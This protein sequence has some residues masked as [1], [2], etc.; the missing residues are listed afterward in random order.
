MYYYQERKTQMNTI[1]FIFSSLFSN[2]KIINESKKR[3][4]WLAIIIVILSCGIAIVPTV[5]SYLNVKGSDVI[6]KAANYSADLSFKQLSYQLANLE[7]VT[8]GINNG[9]FS[10]TVTEDNH[11]SDYTNPVKVLI[12]EDKTWTMTMVYVPVSISDP[13]YNSQ[14][15]ET[16]KTLSLLDPVEKAEDS[17]LESDQ[18]QSK[19]HSMLIFTKSDVYLHLYEGNAMV[20]Y[21]ESN[22]TKTIVKNVDAKASS[23]GTFEK[24]NNLNISAFYDNSESINRDEAYE[25]SLSKWINFFNK[26]YEAPRNSIVLRMSLTFSG[27]NLL[28]IVVMSFTIFILSRTKASIRKYSYLE[29][30]KMIFFASLCPSLIALLIGMMIPSMQNLAFVL[31]LGLRSTWLGMKATSP[32]SSQEAI[33]K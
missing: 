30:L 19:V 23:Y 21:K 13:S 32:A 28:I 29:S 1:K 7:N 15:T 4:W 27:F 3:P 20:T 24:I 17:T 2:Q 18:F 8:A 26:A 16:K 6:T 25:K 10:M 11:T 12:D 31:C 9:E 14:L 22:N 33:R 5:V